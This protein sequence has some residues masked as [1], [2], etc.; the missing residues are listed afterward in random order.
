MYHRIQIL[1]VATAIALLAGV[2]GAKEANIEAGKQLHQ[3]VC[4]SCHGA[5][6]VSEVPEW[7]SLAGQHAG[8]IRYHLESFR[9]E[10][11]YDPQGLMT[12]EAVD[13]SD[14]DIR[15]LAAFFAQQ[16]RPPAQ[17]VSKELAKRGKKIYHAGIRDKDVPSCTGCHGPQGEGI[18]GARYPLVAGQE[19]AYM[20]QA[21]K[22]FKSAER[23]SDSNSEM[24]DIA[25]RMSQD[26][27]KAVAAYMSSLGAQQGSKQD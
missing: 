9:A 3:N 12:P 7:P 17:E 1:T 10:E 20:V 25:S 13:L 2:A 4:L 24:R 14:A 18:K 23:D 26:E 15:N 11:R 6:G 5:S 27:I 21:M 16:E 19:Q 8:Y 22:G